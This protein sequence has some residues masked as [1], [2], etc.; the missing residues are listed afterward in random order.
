MIITYY[1]YYYY[2]S[3]IYRY[4]FWF[5]EK[6]NSRTWTLICFWR[7]ICSENLLCQSV[8]A[9]LLLHLLWCYFQFFFRICSSNLKN[10]NQLKTY[11]GVNPSFGIVGV[12][13]VHCTRTA[14][15]SKKLNPGSPYMGRLCPL[16]LSRV[17]CNC[18]VFHQIFIN[19]CTVK[20]VYLYG[21]IVAFKDVY[22][23]EFLQFF[24]H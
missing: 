15:D 10:G 2:L 13:R 3:T 19:K 24:L 5:C 14:R 16:Q 11:W 18:H 1:L 17:S 9:I 22:L 12:Q 21:H 4:N 6:I 20:I 23:E 7:Q 8:I